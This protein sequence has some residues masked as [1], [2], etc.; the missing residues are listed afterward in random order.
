MNNMQI[1]KMEFQFL[2]PLKKLIKKAL[3][4]LPLIEG[5]LRRYVL[6]KIVF[7]EIEMLL[8]SR[9]SKDVINIAIDIGAAKGGYSWILAPMSQRVVSFEPGYRHY[10]FFKN[11][12]FNSNIE[13][14]NLALGDSATLVELYSI[15][16]NEDSLHTATISK[17]NPLSQMEMAMKHQVRQVTLDGFF[18]KEIKSGESIDFIKID[19]E[20]YELEVVV[21]GEE[22]VRT[23]HP[24]II[25]EIEARHNPNYRQV[26]NFLKEQ[27]YGIFYYD[28]GQFR[29]VDLDS[30]ISMQNH[31]LLDERLSGKVA[32]KNNKYI[33]NFIFQHPNSRFRLIEDL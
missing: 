6:S 30:I 15:G 9:A 11:C 20:G 25:C 23:F 5:I 14:Y 31:K 10:E 1:L 13:L 24:L 18:E 19:V 16:E 26:F 12:L 2:F 4:K 28:S 32:S 7:P 8:L 22:L 33:N 3:K 17:L 29:N 21:G 27:G